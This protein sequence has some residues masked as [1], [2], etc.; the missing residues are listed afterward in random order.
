[1]SEVAVSR[2]LPADVFRV[3]TV[4]FRTRRMR[5]VLSA[6]GVAIGIASMVAVLGIS[7]S[8]K[9]NLIS[10]LDRLGTNLLQV[11]GGQG[12]FT[13]GGELP[14]T[15]PS[16]IGRIGPVSSVSAVIPVTANVYRTDLIPTGQ[17]GGISVV[18][19][20][21][22]LMKTL[23]GTLSTGVFLNAA[24]AR[25]PVTVLG[26]TAA[27]RL[28][29]DRAGVLVWLGGQWFTV[30]GILEPLELAPDLDSA[31]LIGQPIAQSLLGAT[32]TPS[33]IY[34]RATPQS[35]DDVSSVLPATTNPPAPEEVSVSRPSDALA[36]RSAVNTSYTALFLGLGAIALLVGG[37]GIAN[38]MVI[39]VLERRS[40]IGLRRALGAT[41]RHIWGQFLTESAL[42]GL[43]GGLAGIGTGVLATAA[44]ASSRG[45]AVVVPNYAILGG[46]AAALAIGALAGLYPAI[47]AARMSP[48]EALRTT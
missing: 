28:G 5:A 10:T 21:P 33:T 43:L 8:S 6:L 32:T 15:A 39:S 44:Y 40:E 22:T 47:R 34:V 4:A 36:A 14:T 27:A 46:L 45:W 1:M 30:A 26:A 41:K 7:S 19:V 9:S 18:S 3:G 37:V 23:A 20:D 25:Y 29:I 12:L 24:T 31:A 11:T 16:M 38:M 42:I 17:S 2:I 13:A 48:T 35:V